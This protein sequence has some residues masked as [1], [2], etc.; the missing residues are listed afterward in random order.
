MST[1][2]ISAG[3]EMSP[4]VRDISRFR[5]IPRVQVI[6]VPSRKKANVVQKAK[7]F[8]VL[9]FASFLVLSSISEGVRTGLRQAA[10]TAE[11]SG[12]FMVPRTSPAQAPLIQ[13]FKYQVRPV[14]PVGI[15]REENRYRAD[16]ARE[17][18]R[19]LTSVL[20]YVERTTSRLS[21]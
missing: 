16:M 21:R 2:E 6:E 10:R 15:I 5:R 4:S 1:L 8:G 7:F 18:N 13:P 19:F 17:Q 14:D 3:R 20:G 11:A 12:D 9:V